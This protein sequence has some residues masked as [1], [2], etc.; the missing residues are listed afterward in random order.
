MLK[1][2]ITCF[3]SAFDLRIYDLEKLNS[4]IYKVASFEM[5]HEPLMTI[6]QTKKPVIST[7]TSNLQEILQSIN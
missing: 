4:P 6:A 5:L 2:N 1:L 7:G 3:S